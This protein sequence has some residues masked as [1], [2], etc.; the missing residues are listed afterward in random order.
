M[1]RFR[2]MAMAAVVLAAALVAPAPSAADGPGGVGLPYAELAALAEGRPVR[3]ETTELVSVRQ[4]PARDWRVVAT[5][6]PGESLVATAVT[7]GGD[8]WLQVRLADGA[9]G[10][11]RLA[12]VDLSGGSVRRLPIR[13]A[14]PILAMPVLNARD[15]P[16][17][18]PARYPPP[19]W[20]EWT[21]PVLGRSADSEW[22]AA[23]AWDW[24]EY[25]RES[26]ARREP[27]VWL[28]RS[29]ISLLA[30]DLEVEDLPVFVNGLTGGLVVLP[31]DPD[32]KLDPVFVPAPDR[33]GRVGWRWTAG[34]ELLIWT[35]EFGWEALTPDDGGRR[36]IARFRLRA[37]IAPD[38]AHLAAVL[39]R[40]NADVDDLLI[41][42]VDGGDP[43]LVE[44]IFASRWRDCLSNDLPMPEAELSWSP[45]GR[46]LLAPLALL[47]YCLPADRSTRIVGVDGRVVRLPAVD[48]P[49]WLSQDKASLIDWEWRPNGGVILRS[50]RAIYVASR[51]GELLRT[52]ELPEGAYGSAQWAGDDIQLIVAGSGEWFAVNLESG[53]LRSIVGMP[54]FTTRMSYRTQV[55]VRWSGDGRRAAIFAK[56][57]RELTLFDAASMS[58]AK[59]PMAELRPGIADAIRWGARLKW[60]PTGDRL[61]LYPNPPDGLT[62]PWPLY[63][64]EVDPFRVRQADLVVGDDIVYPCGATPQWSPD[65]ELF[66]VQVQERL[67]GRAFGVDG[68]RAPPDA[69]SRGNFNV[70]WI[71]VYDRAGRFVRAFRTMDGVRRS[72]TEVGWSFDGRWLAIGEESTSGCFSHA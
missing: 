18:S 30:E 53:E 39:R 47:E 10:W 50:E 13:S 26:P 70:G 68:L 51:E 31:V 59:V 46:A 21:I 35:G 63:I 54:T 22:V 23:P 27:T 48:A 17:G 33:W 8:P 69:D 43:V 52:I 42:P 62:N 20:S 64:V 38:G 2:A 60:S 61:L 55:E 57:T 56:R 49:E 14:P 9:F 36:R 58:A 67:G 15:W 4:R 12:E 11:L 16:T 41:A 25:S 32:A 65:G 37:L 40:E 19:R 45:D 6:T 3:V 24:E 5:L 71:M 28:H 72:F 7:P 66:T 34:G 1:R 29:E 44:A